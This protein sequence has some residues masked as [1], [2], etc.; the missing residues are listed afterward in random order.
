[1]IVSDDGEVE[2]YPYWIPSDPDATFDRGWSDRT[3]LKEP[4]DPL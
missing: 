4:P 1:M 2:F 3:P